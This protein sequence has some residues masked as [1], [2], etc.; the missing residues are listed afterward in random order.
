MNKVLYLL[1]VL[2]ISVNVSMAQPGFMKWYDFGKSVYFH[3]IIEDNNSLIIVGHIWKEGESRQDAFF[4]RMDTTGNVLSMNTYA[5]S[6]GSHLA[7]RTGWPLLKSKYG[8]FISID[9]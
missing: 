1:L 3:N 2:S 4:V 8:G 6:L 7:F 9:D 5:D